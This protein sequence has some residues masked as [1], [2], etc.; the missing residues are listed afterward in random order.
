MQHRNN[1]NTG[2]PGGQQNHWNDR[3]QE[4]KSVNRQMVKSIIE[5]GFSKD[6]L[7]YTEEIGKSIRNV[8]TSQIRNAYGELTRIKMKAE[9][10][11]KIH[12]LLMLKPKLAYAV[13]RV[14]GDN[15]QHIYLAENLSVAIDVVAVASESDRINYFNNFASFFEAILAY[16]K[17]NGG[18]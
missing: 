9:R 14:T 2:R 18:K 3:Q 11:F 17:A 12:D 4:A 1:P 7:E 13:G 10:D 8:T 5:N 6:S 15:K 16:H